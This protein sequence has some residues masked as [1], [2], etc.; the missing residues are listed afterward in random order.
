MKAKRVKQISSWYLAGYARRFI[1]FFFLAVRSLVDTLAAV[2]LKKND[3]LCYN[4]ALDRYKKNH[5]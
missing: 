5:E 2:E 4:E 1:W 3:L